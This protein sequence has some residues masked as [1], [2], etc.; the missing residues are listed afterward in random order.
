MATQYPDGIDSTSSLPYVTNGTSPM[1]GDD[2]N[3]LRDAIVAVET[4]LGIN[5]SGTFTSV[6]ARL[7]VTEAAIAGY[8]NSTF[9]VLSADGFVSQ[10]RVFSPSVNFDVVDGGAGANFEIDLAAN[11]GIG[12]ITPASDYSLTLDGDGATRIGGVTLRNTGTDTFYIG[13]ATASDS[14][15]ISLMNP[16]TGYVTL[17]TDGTE[18]I[19]ITSTGDVGLGTTLP[20]G[21]LHVSGGDLLVDTGDVGIGTLTPSELLHISGGNLL[22]ESAAGAGLPYATMKGTQ[23]G[24]QMSS[25][26]GIGKLDVLDSTGA[27]TISLLNNVD[28]RLV[29]V[30][31]ADFSFYT[32]NTE[33]MR[34]TA[35]GNFG[36]GI[37]VPT[38]RGHF[39]TGQ[40]AEDLPILALQNNSGTFNIYG[41]NGSPE[42][43]IAG[44]YGDV[45]SDITSGTIFTKST[46]SG[47]TGWRPIATTE[48]G[49]GG[50]SEVAFFNSSGSITSDPSL[51]FSSGRLSVSLTDSGVATV[52]GL[53]NSDTTDGNGAALSFRTD[54]TG[55]GA[56]T[57]QELSAVRSSF[58]EH[59]HATRS[60]TMALSISNSGTFTEVIRLS[61]DARVGIGTTSPAAKLDI[62]SG[63]DTWAAWGSGT[64]ATSYMSFK[65]G[66]T[67][68]HVG[69]VGTDGGGIVVGGTGD[70]FGIRSENDL[71]LMAGAA[72]R[73]RI[74]S[75]GSIGVGTSSPD[76]LLHV[77]TSDSS[78]ISDAN[79][80]AI[81]EK[82][83]TGYVQLLTP[84]ANES[85]LLF[86]NASNS[87]SGGI[88]YN[89]ASTLNGL[90]FRAGGNTTRAVIKSTGEVGIG[91]TLPQ[92]MLHVNGNIRLGIGDADTMVM[93]DADLAMVADS[94]VLIVSDVNQ[95]GTPAA[96]IIFGAGSASALNFA[97]YA[98]KFPTGLPTL[99][100]MIIKGGTGAVG[101]GVTSPAGRL[102][103]NNGAA[104]TDIF[105][106]QEDGVQV[107][108]L[109]NGMTPPSASNSI[110]TAGTTGSAS[111]NTPQEHHLSHRLTT[112]V[113]F[114]DF[115]MGDDFIGSGFANN[116]IMTN[117]YI[118]KKQNTGTVSGRVAGLVVQNHPG[119][120]DLGVTALNDFATVVYGGGSGWT[121]STDQ[122]FKLVGYF[123]IRALNGAD[124]QRFVFGVTS[125]N[126]GALSGGDPDIIGT[127]EVMLIYD[128][129]STAW[130]SSINGVIDTSGITVVSG[131]NKLEVTFT[132]GGSNVFFAVNGVIYSRGSVTLP[133][134]DADQYVWAGVK[135]V[136]GS[137][138]TFTVGV[139][140]ISFSL[141][142]ITR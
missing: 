120:V 126:V 124:G 34:I 118:V 30:N 72:E 20:A 111:W 46:A 33:K 52:V 13:S 82:S 141:S 84:D 94:D 1:V 3:R 102:V 68:G 119:V 18:R 16:N 135:K 38:A 127:D 53:H 142:G 60:S 65:Q 76:S 130:K 2:V 137:T 113:H 43:V 25:G 117:G 89:N 41:A 28:N 21:R 140:C 132:G 35:G 39:S 23:G 129:T 19:R 139:D 66:G 54:T 47:S 64:T 85:G 122:V 134:L 105:V 109:A 49:S 6:D 90:Q 48:A 80:I 110:L 4:E 36:V 108:A 86:G 56:A 88:I 45:A 136:T 24:F 73:A 55:V 67:S 44:S 87:A 106:A 51:T 138:T 99:R 29:G 93:G 97:S 5:P 62:A 8:A 26:N 133:P 131:W 95:T 96:D 63:A 32:N 7:G 37:S 40:P 91:T 75:A 71:I 61:S 112:L 128:N 9:L 114:E 17:G 98:T 104:A 50:E 78:G 107:F 42:G 10:E 79:A 81:F 116:D 83:G 57:D 101:I 92:Q 74:S 59:D 115:V 22:L 70:N 69:Y 125:T 11:V 121:V 100:H 77:M 27:V 31:N 14:A 103:V 12:T 15:N 58:T 123:N